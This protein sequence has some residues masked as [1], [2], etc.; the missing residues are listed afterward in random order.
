MRV[1]DHYLQVSIVNSLLIHLHPYGA[2]LQNHH[3]TNRHL[4]KISKF[5]SRFCP[6]ETN[7]RETLL[8]FRLDC[9]VSVPVG[10]ILSHVTVSCGI[11]IQHRQ[12][13]LNPNQS[14]TKE[15]VQ[16]LFKINSY[17]PTLSHQFLDRRT[18]STLRYFEHQKLQR[19]KEKYSLK[20]LPL[21]YR[22]SKPEGKW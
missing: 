16:K 1:L 3:W 13:L 15:G 7:N 14:F 18:V 17:L 22:Y 8:V 12:L 5:D 10:S 4:N 6:I 19:R 2:P 11:S 9:I 21:D 20:M